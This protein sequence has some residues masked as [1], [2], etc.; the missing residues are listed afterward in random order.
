MFVESLYSYTL[1][2]PAGEILSVQ[3]VDGIADVLR[4]HQGYEF[5]SRVLVGYR[6]C[7]M[8]D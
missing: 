2:S 8:A 5:I 7:G 6:N 3:S 4:E 1:V